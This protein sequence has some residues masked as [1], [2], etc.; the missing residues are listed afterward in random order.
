MCIGVDLKT[1]KTRLWSNKLAQTPRYWPNV[2]EELIVTQLVKKFSA[3]YETR[4]FITVF[5][6]TRHRSLSLA[7]WIQPTLLQHEHLRSI[8]I[9]SS[10]LRTVLWSDIFPYGYLT[11]ILCLLLTSSWM[12]YV[13]TIIFFYFMVLTTSTWAM[14]K[15]C[16]WRTKTLYYPHTIF[17][18]SFQEYPTFS[19]DSH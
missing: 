3:F 17:R 8:L 12:L 13:P 14:Y 10:Y 16:W 4:S 11:I 7:S 6:R 18:Q 1:E 19:C 15:N 2:W 5:T 9:L